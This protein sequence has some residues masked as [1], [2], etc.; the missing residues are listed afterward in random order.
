MA[1]HA[2]D[3]PVDSAWS[4]QDDAAAVRALKAWYAQ[5]CPRCGSDG[6]IRYGAKLGCG[7]CGAI[8]QAPPP[9]A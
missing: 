8:S 6:A 9:V 4:A 3:E 5:L 2:A 7:R 1:Q